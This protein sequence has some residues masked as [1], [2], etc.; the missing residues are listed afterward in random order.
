ML[1]LIMG[2]HEGMY[3]KTLG[4]AKPNLRIRGRKKKFLYMRS[5]KS[6]DS[7]PLL[8]LPNMASSVTGH[9]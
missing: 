8:Y 3:I 6:R 7:P 2:N 5:K 4:S 1:A 9:G